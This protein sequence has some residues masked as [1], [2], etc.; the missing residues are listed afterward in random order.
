MIWDRVTVSPELSIGDLR[1]AHLIASLRLQGRRSYPLSDGLCISA[2]V[3]Y[4]GSDAKLG[5][6]PLLSLYRRCKISHGCVESRPPH[7]L[8]R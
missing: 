7:A 8:W 1:G 5:G 3:S 2:E 6:T 4:C